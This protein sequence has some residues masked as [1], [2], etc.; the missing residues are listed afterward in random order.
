M[1][2]EAAGHAEVDPIGDVSEKNSLGHLVRIEA[3]S[4]YY[5]TLKI[6]KIKAWLF[7]RRQVPCDSSTTRLPLVLEWRR[8]VRQNKR[9][10]TFGIYPSNPTEMEWEVK[11]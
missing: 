3:A 1:L 11:N 8:A 4:N 5:S 2:L 9:E 10:V 6:A 7:R